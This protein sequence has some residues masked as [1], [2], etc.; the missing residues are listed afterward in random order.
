MF[1]KLSIRFRVLGHV[2][3][4]LAVE[5]PKSEASELMWGDYLG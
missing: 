4:N 1:C 3:V 2:I 5:S